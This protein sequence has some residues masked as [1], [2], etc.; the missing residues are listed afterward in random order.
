MLLVTFLAIN[1]PAYAFLTAFSPA[2]P[3]VMPLRVHQV[4]FAGAMAPG[5]PFLIV[6]QLV[7]A[8]VSAGLLVPAVWLFRKQERYLLKPPP[9][10]S[11]GP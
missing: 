6:N 4:L 2:C 9:L 10:G 5:Y 7:L 11:L 3:L 8:G 1:V